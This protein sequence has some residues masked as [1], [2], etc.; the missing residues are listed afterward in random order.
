MRDSPI[1]RS[2]DPCSPRAL[3]DVVY[4][5]LPK[6]ATVIVAALALIQGVFLSGQLGPNI[7]DSP[8]LVAA[9]PSRWAIHAIAMD[10]IVHSP[11][12]STRRSFE[13]FMMQ[14]GIL[15]GIGVN[16]SSAKDV[17]HMA[18]EIAKH[19]AYS[20]EE[21]HKAHLAWCFKNL[22]SNAEAVLD[23]PQAVIDE[24]DPQ[25]ILDSFGSSN[26]Y[27]RCLTSLFMIGAARQV[28]HVLRQSRPSRVTSATARRGG[29]M[30][31]K[32]RALG[33]TALSVTC[34]PGATLGGRVALC[35][36][37]SQPDARQAFLEELVQARSTE[38][39][40]II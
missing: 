1:C 4:I 10:A 29:G 13:M 21:Q 5:V 32:S 17:T 2:A 28:A 8:G 3:T 11:F 33:R 18:V 9:S 19:E 39:G 23:I 40:G 22:Q 26:W 30:P 37:H 34:R 16:T 27:A 25:A 6:N 15:P 38:Q 31:Y 20:V 12:S 7:V 14:Q 36:S 24:I 35:G